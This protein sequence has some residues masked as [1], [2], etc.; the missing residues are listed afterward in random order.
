[1]T[2]I[3]EEQ[4][5]DEGT[6]NGD[7]AGGNSGV[8]VYL[9]QLTN[10]NGEPKYK[11]PEEALKGAVHA[12]QHIK[13]LEEELAELRV[14]AQEGEVFAKVLEKLNGPVEKDEAKPKAE[15][16]LS[17]DDVAKVVDQLLTQRTTESTR[18]QNVSTVTS[19]FKQLYGDKASETLY[20]KAEDLGFTKEGI[21]ELIASNPKAALK[22]LGAEGGTPAPEADP[23]VGGNVNAQN[24]GAKQD[25]PLESSM[26][27]IS[28]KDLTENFRKSRSATYKR[29][30]ID[31]SQVKYV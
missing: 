25:A 9:S 17:V 26:G 1:M 15:N 8:E 18:K 24:L 5:K 22:I 21:N 30:G 23:I 13:T 20:G 11:T 31:E 28:E 19:K 4:P 7:Q 2:D 6:P 16:S 29:L 12:Q 3:F 27:Y 10:E 14:K